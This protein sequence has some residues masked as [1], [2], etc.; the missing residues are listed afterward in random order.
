M[1]KHFL[2]S[3]IWILSLS[4][5]QISLAAPL[6]DQLPSQLEK[7][8]EASI[9]IKIDGSLDEAVWDKIPWTDG[10]RI[11][12][13]DTLE[14]TSLQTQV[15]IFYTEAGLYIGSWN[16]QA[17]ETL[18]ER[19]SSRDSWLTRD[20]FTVTLDTSGEGLYGYW[21]GVNLGG[22]LSDGTVLP[23]RQ[24]STEWD[25][26]WRANTVKLEDGW[27]A[28]MF[29][30]WSMMSMPDSTGDVRKLGIYL[31][32]SV[33]HKNQSWSIPALPRTTGLFM[34]RLHNVVLRDINPKKQVTFYP[35]ISSSFDSIKNQTKAKAGFDIFWRPTTNFQVTSSINPDFGNVESDD[36]VVNL[37]S[38]ETFYPEKRPFFLEG[39]EIFVTSPRASRYGGGQRKTPITL[40]NTRRIG[41]PAR[42]PDEDG[43]E[44]SKLEQNQPSELLG[45]VKV[46]GQSGALRYGI[47]AAFEN[48]TDFNGVVDSEPVTVN[49]TGRDFSAARLLYEQ[50]NDNGRRS[51]GLIATQ[52]SHTDETANT[53]GI[54]AHYLSGTGKLAA[55][56]QGLASYIEGLQG[57]GIF[58]D[59]A[60][61]PSQGIKHGLTLDFFDRDL[62]INHFGYLQ[63][64]DAKSYRYSLERQR[65]RLENFISIRDNISFH[66]QWN[67]D[68]LMTRSALSM[69][70]QLELKNYAKLDMG[71]N[72]FPE[73]YEDLDSKG[74][75]AY[76]LI[77]RWQFDAD[78]ESNNA[79]KVVFE[80]GV[81]YRQ[82]DIGGH[83][84]S[85]D[86][87][88]KFRPNDRFSATLKVVLEESNGWLLHRSDQ[89][90][91]RYNATT[92]RP[93][94][95]ISYFLSA[96]QQFKV[97]AQ[98]IGI[99]AFERDRW[100]IES[101]GGHLISTATPA[102]EKG[103]RDFSISR[104][105]FQARYRWELA[106]LSDLFVV[107]TRGSNVGSD[108]NKNFME[109][110]QDSWDEAL[111]DS[112]IIKL[113][114][115]IGN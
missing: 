21:F 102:S 3:L 17:V 28:E 29:L 19:L 44:L 12:E 7:R 62:Q 90:F 80:T 99:K 1:T 72:F 81:K 111:V 25:G 52:V 32:R 60:Y 26:P 88:I 59:L 70:K 30:P 66:Q 79:K 24:Y 43:L 73:R 104:L 74:N 91:T 49:Q 41:S 113:R 11:T 101:D 16:E 9:D 35:F 87:E 47:L 2:Y 107:Y 103:S 14:A 34:S 48:E 51:V 112:L 71:M 38:Y 75:G 39:Q 92:W 68:G 83:K 37:T 77:D 85:Y 94:I 97:V 105:S 93:N 4:I 82:E 110:L 55:D 114:Y 106:P 63:R 108:I 8:S 109:Q 76:Q 64:N 100:R 69:S 89:E 20:R 15:K 84:M 96:R 13:P 22:S 98:W 10:L 27:S 54:D 23:E 115:R 86:A 31:Q 61:R 95:D 46:T 67:L 18:V 6:R 57:Q 33:A 78:W 42:T 45:A 53:Y 50:S 58:A 40:L 56:I 5:C 36:I 65:S